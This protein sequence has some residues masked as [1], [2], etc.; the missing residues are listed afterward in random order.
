MVTNL[1]NKKHWDDFNKNYSNNWRSISKELLSQREIKFINKFLNKIDSPSKILDIGVGNG[2]ILQ[3]LIKNTND[4]TEIF[5][6]DLSDKMVEVCKEKFN[7]EHKIK[8]INSCDVAEDGIC[9]EDKFNFISAIRVVK[10]NINWQKMIKNIYTKL[11]KEGIFVFTMLN[12]NSISRFANFGIPVYLTTKDEIRNILNK[13]NFKILEI[14]CFSKL[15]AFFYSINN[16][17]YAKL[18]ILIEKLLEKLL[19]ANFFGKEF[20]VAVKKST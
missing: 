18:L 10:Y 4:N 7:N 9:F 5:G 11:D 15:P 16:K 6:I 20:F 2:R 13:N 1:E 12:N 19:G 3:N 8:S 17:F 14:N